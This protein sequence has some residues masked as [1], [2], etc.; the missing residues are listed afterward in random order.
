MPRPGSGAGV[1]RRGT[2]LLAATLALLARG[3]RLLPASRTGEGS[4][5]GDEAGTWR[6][7]GGRHG[8]H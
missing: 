3:E 6:A 2:R 4:G 8:L 5:R 1:A 7:G